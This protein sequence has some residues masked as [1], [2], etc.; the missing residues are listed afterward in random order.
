[1]S[2]LDTIYK[3][4]LEG[5]APSTQTGVTAALTEGIPAETIL[6]EALIKA[7]TEV[8][9]LFETGEYYVPEMLVA[10]RAMKGGL[11]L[12]RPALADANVKAIGKIVVGTVQGD[13]HD[14][15]KNL[16]AMMMEGAG[17]EVIDLGAD[18]APEKFVEA[19]NTHKPNLVGMSALLTTTMPKMKT[20][21]EALNT[22]AVRN[23]IK[24][25]VGGAP[26]TARY[27]KEIGAD[28]YSPDA[29][30]AANLAKS[31]LAK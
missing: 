23:S 2:N 9:H 27:A 17:F 20:T 6:N 12:L 10:A 31:L 25:M 13:L 5:A 14:I 26:V 22:E 18:V 4:V 24:V 28:A 21:I 15:G 16:V 3:S 29:A 30:G 7:M 19:V 8:G 1:M 11:E